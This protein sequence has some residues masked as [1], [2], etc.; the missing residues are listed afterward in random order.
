MDSHGRLHIIKKK[1]GSGIFVLF[2]QKKNC[3][4]C[5]SIGHECV[6]N[7]PAI[8]VS[9]M[10]SSSFLFVCNSLCLPF[11]SLCSLYIFYCLINVFFSLYIS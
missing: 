6:I 7:M 2:L 4:N 11:T 9:P 10:F 1:I 5:V 3:T 8:G